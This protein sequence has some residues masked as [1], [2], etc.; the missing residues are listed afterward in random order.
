MKW[1]EKAEA[2]RP[3]GNDDAILRWNS[4]ARIIMANNLTP[5]PEETVEHF[6]E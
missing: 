5:R 6:L 3:A 2:K 1:F 4:C